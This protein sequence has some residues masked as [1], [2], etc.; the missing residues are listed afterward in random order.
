[1]LLLGVLQRTMVTFLQALQRVQD[2]SMPYFCPTKTSA[3]HP[4]LTYLT[5]DHVTVKKHATP[6]REKFG[7]YKK[8]DTYIP[9]QQ[10]ASG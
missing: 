8:K 10:I 7:K 6:E 4:N 2:I 5:A 3:F 9:Y 1:M